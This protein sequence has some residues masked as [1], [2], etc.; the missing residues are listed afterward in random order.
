MAKNKLKRI[1]IGLEIVTKVIKSLAKIKNERL[2]LDAWES[3]YIQINESKAKVDQKIISKRSFA[4][5]FEG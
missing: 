3:L 1:K 4:T 5:G 2:E